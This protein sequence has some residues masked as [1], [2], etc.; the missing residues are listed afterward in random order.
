MLHLEELKTRAK[1]LKRV[2]LASKPKTPSHRDEPQ[3][4]EPEGSTLFEKDI[5]ELSR[6]PETCPT[7][8]SRRPHAEPGH[9]CR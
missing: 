8:P 5:I 1:R 2:G 7:Q 4:V 3:Q 6:R 9:N